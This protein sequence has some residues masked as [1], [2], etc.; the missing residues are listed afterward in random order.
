MNR[1]YENES[2][3]AAGRAK[4]ITYQLNSQNRKDMCCLQSIEHSA[5][6][7][8]ADIEPTLLPRI[9]ALIRRECGQSEFYTALIP[10]APDLMS[11]ID[12]RA[13]IDD[14]IVENSRDIAAVEATLAELTMKRDEL[15]NR[16]A[17]M[18]SKADTQG[19]D[20][21]DEHKVT[22]CGGKK[23]RI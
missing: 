3:H 5:G 13:L 1:R 21:S 11:Y 7:N 9:L 4:V 22:S 18:D 16:R 23:R 14:A 20:E 15:H 19:K 10:M 6:S 17:C 8:F 12:R 2:S